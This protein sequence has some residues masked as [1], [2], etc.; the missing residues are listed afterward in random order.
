MNEITDTASCYV[1]KTAN[2]S[3][4]VTGSR[5]SLDSVVYA[6]WDGK[7]AEAIV[8][9][10]PSLSAEQVYGAI[11]FYLR[12]QTAIDRYL[13]EQDTRWQQ[14]AERSRQQHGPLLD[15]LRARQRANIEPPQTA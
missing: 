5:V 15:R 11:A 9:E 13:A 6:Y 3:W 1:E 12:H 4:R 2:D 7:S 14:L 10:F 8:E